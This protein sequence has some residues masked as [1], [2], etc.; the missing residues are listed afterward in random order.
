MIPKGKYDQLGLPDKYGFINAWKKH[1]MNDIENNVGF[2]DIHQ[3]V[4]IPFNYSRVF[5][6]EQNLACA[7]KNG[8]TGFINRKGNVVIPFVYTSYAKFDKHGVVVINKGSKEVL[9]DTL[10]HEI[11]NASHTYAEIR[12][13]FPHDDVLWIMKG[14]K[15]AFFDLKGN[16]LTPFV[17]DNM[18]PA[19]LHT[20][21]N[22]Y[23]GEDLRWFYKG[24]SVV[25]KDNQFLVLN[26]HMDYV[27][28]PGTYQWISPLSYS[29]LMIVKQNDRFGLLNHQLSLIQPVEFDTISNLPGVGHEPNF[30]SF[31]AKKNGKYFVF[32]S[33]G[34]WKDSIEY[35]TIRL[36]SYNHYLVGKNGKH[37]RLDKYGNRLNEEFEFIREE[38]RSFVAR[39][40]SLL[41]LIDNEGNVILP[42]EYEDIICQHL[43][44]IYVKK[45]GKWGV[46]D[47]DNKQLLPFKYDY[48]ADAWD[49]SK[50]QNYIVVMNDKFGKVTEKDVEIFPCLYDGI[51]TWVEYGPAGHYVMTG[52]KMG[53]INYKGK[54]LIPV[55]YDKVDCV[56]ETSFAEISD[57]GK[58]GLYDFSR[59]SFLLPLEYDYIFV[60]Y[61]SVFQQKPVRIITYKGGKVNILD[62]TGKI[63][64]SNVSKQEIKKEFEVDLDACGYIPCSYPLLL[65]KHNRT[66]QAPDCMMREYNERYTPIESIYYK[67]GD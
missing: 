11:I 45:H 46:V 52:N 19:N 40:D 2:I 17:F 38:E 20:A 23:F 26:R 36:L 51:T 53:L 50:E 31:W 35:D 3:K 5:S 59:K 14:S 62:K 42:F 34:C 27:V 33:L 67:M 47:D 56:S 21:P 7:K 44:N 13:N 37:W 57:K 24:L 25:E 4:L 10:G 66:Y 8:K 16:P 29:G 64:R 22:V 55:I 30:P 61:Y 12:E 1:S 41:G 9:L 48:I 58:M 18:Y 43:G 60:D 63:I 39:K 15:W 65:M 54:V 32:D 28:T 49:D 6:F